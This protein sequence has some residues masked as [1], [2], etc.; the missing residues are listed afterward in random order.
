MAFKVTFLKS[1]NIKT[2]SNLKAT[3]QHSPSATHCCRGQRNIIEAE[4]ETSWRKVT[5]L[6]QCEGLAHWTTEGI[7]PRNMRPWG[8]E[9]RQTQPGLES[10]LEVLERVQRR[11]VE[12]VKGL[13]R[14]S[15]EDWLG[16]LGVLS[17]EKMRLRRDPYCSL[18]LP[19]R[20][21]QWGGGQSFLPGNKQ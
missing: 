12:L 13:E 6:C 17:L 19:E 4:G 21:V 14:K 10:V 20:M 3:W 15:C 16:E 5:G 8:E 9:W 18:Q 2:I 7:S 11:S 1:P